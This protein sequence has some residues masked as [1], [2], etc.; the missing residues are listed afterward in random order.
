[1]NALLRANLFLLLLVAVFDPVDQTH[2]KAPLFVGVWILFLTDIAISRHGRYQVPANLYLYM[3]IF[4]VF[5]PLMGLLI[6]L[7]R[8]GGMEGYEGFKYWKSYLFLTLC[9]PVAVKRL[10]LSRPLSIVLS[11]LSV[12][13]ICL[14]L[15]ALSDDLL[16]AQLTAFADAYVVF[17]V[18][19]RS[20]GSLSYQSV[21]FHGTPLIVIAI[22]Y[23]CYQSLRSTG[24]AKLWNVLFLM[25]NVCGM[26]LSG[27][28][29]N[30]IV[31]LLTPL[32][33]MG[34]YKGTKTRVAIAV[35]LVLVVIAGFSSGVFQAMLSPYDDSNAIKLAHLHDY[36]I[37]F[38]D[39]KTLL[40][41][42]G[43]GASFFSTAWGT[44]VTLTE[45][46]Y[47]EFIRNYGLM[48]APIFYFLILYPLRILADPEARADHYLFLAYG[49]YLYMCSGNPLL[50]SS[51]GMLVLAVVLV[52][53][54]C[55]IVAIP[56]R[57]TVANVGVLSTGNL[58]PALG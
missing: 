50:L 16:R 51:S 44:R 3:F 4:V 24:R 43:L 23:F 52:K 9:I 12:A 57:L 7:L 13:T 8:G 31:G 11:L 55:N 5:L 20:Y 58:P 40:F 18:T 27:S 17:S 39:W 37:L 47:L 25:L 46:T 33:V 26:V 10:D 42:Q 56:R 15:I 1:M 29:N 2:L 48:L 49:A 36:G 21:Y 41:G 45:V 19:D 53:T 32:M 30:M 14:Y 34:W 28:R 22:A 35:L 6:Y 38:G 54:F